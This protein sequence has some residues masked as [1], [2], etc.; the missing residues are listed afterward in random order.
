[1]CIEIMEYMKKMPIDRNDFKVDNNLHKYASAF[2]LFYN[3]LISKTAYIQ[4]LQLIL[5]FL[6][7]YLRFDKTFQVN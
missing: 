1:M 6:E 5:I 3:I 2:C 7:D 4:L